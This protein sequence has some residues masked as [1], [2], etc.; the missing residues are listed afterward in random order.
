MREKK[1]GI[2]MSFELLTKKEEAELNDVELVAY[3]EALRQHYSSAKFNKFVNKAHILIH[4]LLVG[5]MGSTYKFKVELIDDRRE[6]NSP[7]CIF[8]V[9]HTCVHD[10]PVAMKIFK[11]QAYVIAGD[12]VRN[13]INGIMFTLNGVSFVNRGSAES[14][15]SAKEKLYLYL[16]HKQNVMIFPEATWNR[17]GSRGTDERLMME[18]WPGAVD[19][20]K[21]TN[22]PIVPIILEYTGDVCYSIIGK[23]MYFPETESNDL[24]KQKLRDE[25]ASMKWEIM[26]KYC[27]A[28]WEDVSK[29]Q[30][31]ALLQ[32]YLDEYPK[33]DPNFEDTTIFKNKYITSPKDAFRHLDEIDFNTGNAY[34]LN[35]RLT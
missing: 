7:N 5:A 24:S 29:E 32:S 12:E 3:H 26:D 11:K 31:E 33:L 17:L 28:K 4:P 2:I 6:N 20:S 16:M 35:K 27:R 10:V 21:K 22:V 34:L 9:N 19:L 15:A 13:D 30:F 25:M 18:L 1:R 23:E 14:R 8:A